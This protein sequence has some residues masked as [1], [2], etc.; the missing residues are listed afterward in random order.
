MA[1]CHVS[2]R[3]A[4]D[5]VGRRR[6]MGARVEPDVGVLSR[7]EFLVKFLFYFERAYLYVC[8]YCRAEIVY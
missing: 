5:D 4:R 2:Q 6:S 7:L 1:V 8:M 3:G